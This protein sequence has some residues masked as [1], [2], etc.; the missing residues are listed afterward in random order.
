[1]SSAVANPVLFLP[2]FFSWDSNSVCIRDLPIF[3]RTSAA[4][5]AVHHLP[6]QTFSTCLTVHEDFWHPVFRRPACILHP[7][8]CFSPS[9]V[10]PVCLSFTHT[11]YTSI[12][13]VQCCSP[14]SL[15]NWKTI[16]FIP[17][18]KFG[19]WGS[20]QEWYLFNVNKDPGA[21][22]SN[23]CFLPKLS[24]FN[25]MNL[26]FDFSIFLINEKPTLRGKLELTC[27]LTGQCS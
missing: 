6:L 27:S 22:V 25:K 5:V 26:Y 11:L 10:S 19:N 4:G 20:E 16:W 15:Q 8:C 21:L 18:S 17:I 24:T 2:D 3:S 12:I 7:S 13:F 14:V 9:V 23:L 1:M